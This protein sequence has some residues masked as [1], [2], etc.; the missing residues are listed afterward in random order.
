MS[1]DE[2]NDIHD[3]HM[4]Q[5]DIEKQKVVLS[6]TDLFDTVTW[7][8]HVNCEVSGPKKKSIDRACGKIKCIESQKKLQQKEINGL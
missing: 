3:L 7:A 6:T 8:N 5:C 4:N 1:I 2:K